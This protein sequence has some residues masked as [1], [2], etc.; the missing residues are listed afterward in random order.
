MG[1]TSD[2]STLFECF[3]DAGAD[4]VYPTSRITTD[5]GAE[6]CEV[7]DVGNISRVD[8]EGFDLDHHVIVSKFW[9]GCFDKLDVA[10]RL[11]GDGGVGHF[12]S[13]GWNDAQNSMMD[14]M[15]KL[16]DEHTGSDEFKL[17]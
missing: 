9:N 3:N 14:R 7:V 5:T 4:F 6:R 13:L 2:P 17:R 10:R 8:D 11:D 16:D 1:E 12:M 15:C